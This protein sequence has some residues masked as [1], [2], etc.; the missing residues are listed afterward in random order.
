M[1]WSLDATACRAHDASCRICVATAPQW[2]TN[3]ATGTKA[4]IYRQPAAVDR[5]TMARVASQ[6]PEQAIT[7]DAQTVIFDPTKNKSTA[8]EIP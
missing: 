6:C 1:P 5:P 4:E 2:F 8:S 7:E 3:A